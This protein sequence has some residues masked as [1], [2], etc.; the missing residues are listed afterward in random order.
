MSLKYNMDEV[1]KNRPSKIWGRQ[2]FKNYTWSILK[3][4]APYI[5]SSISGWSPNH[6][7]SY[8]HLT[9]LLLCIFIHNLPC[10]T[11]SFYLTGTL[12]DNGFRKARL[13]PLVWSSEK[14]NIETCVCFIFTEDL[15]WPWWITT[16][17]GVNNCVGRF[18]KTFHNNRRFILIQDS[19]GSCIVLA[20]E[21][22]KQKI[23]KLAILRF[24]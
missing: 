14:A 23:T 8:F 22:F 11:I 24:L 13:L 17:F 2:P 3:Y 6:N 4:F 19:F 21:N 9:I 12:V 15:C 20:T 7:P 16:Q 5:S 18:L 10:K 1:F